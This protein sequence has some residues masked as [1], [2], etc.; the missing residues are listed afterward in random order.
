MGTQISVRKY[1]VLT[2]ALVV[3]LSLFVV[4]FAVEAT[5]IGTNVSTGGTMAVTGVTTL[6][7]ALIGTSASLSVNFEASGYAS[8][9][10]AIIGGPVASISTGARYT[11]EFKSSNPAA[12][13]SVLF[14]G[15]ASNKGTCLQMKDQLGNNVYVR[16]GTGATASAQAAQG[17]AHFLISTTSCR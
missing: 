3:V 17:S 9:A 1:N 8:A 15:G 6:S 13:T 10:F 16:I 7:S 11:A 4:Y 5:T 14:S 12:S 2:L